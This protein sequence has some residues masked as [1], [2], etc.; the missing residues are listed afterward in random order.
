[1][2][3]GIQAH[4]CAAEGASHSP[5]FQVPTKVR[6]RGTWSGRELRQAGRCAGREAA[7]R[8]TLPATRASDATR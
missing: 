5:M 1:M 4:S 3:A 8:A 2:P 6:R 7:A